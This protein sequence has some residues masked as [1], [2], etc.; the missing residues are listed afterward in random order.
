MTYFLPIGPSCIQHAHGIHLHRCFVDLH[1]FMA[2]LCKKRDRRKNSRF[3][4]GNLKCQICNVRLALH[5]QT[6]ITAR[7]P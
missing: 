5:P 4:I 6:P 7:R 1:D 3:G 2:V